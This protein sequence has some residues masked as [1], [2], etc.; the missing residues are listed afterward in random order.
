MKLGRDTGNAREVQNEAERMQRTM[1]LT[2]REEQ[3]EGE[4]TSK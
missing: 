1:I 3:S 4:M 2:I